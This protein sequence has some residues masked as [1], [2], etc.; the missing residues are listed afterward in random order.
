M[1]PPPGP[2]PELLRRPVGPAFMEV[3]FYVMNISS[4]AFILK[5]PILGIFFFFL[6]SILKIGISEQLDGAACPSAPSKLAGG[7]PVQDTPGGCGPEAAIASDPPRYFPRTAAEC[8]SCSPP[9]LAGNVGA[10]GGPGARERPLAVRPC[11]R[12][13]GKRGP[14]GVRPWGVSGPV[15]RPGFP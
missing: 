10:R 6:V 9:L 14:G 4:F 15:R 5:R 7:H 1:P 13:V 2:R 11:P 8:W 12:L 3:A